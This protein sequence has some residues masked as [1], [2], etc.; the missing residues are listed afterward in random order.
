MVII[1]K[2]DADNIQ[3]GRTHATICAAGQSD[4]AIRACYGTGEFR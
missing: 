3:F 2:T 4:M 1:A